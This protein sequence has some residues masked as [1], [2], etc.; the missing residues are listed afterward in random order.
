MAGTL[1]DRTITV[2]SIVSSYT[3]EELNQE[4]HSKAEYEN[5]I[6]A[7][8]AIYKIVNFSDTKDV[9]TL[10]KYA[11]EWIRQNYYDGVLSFT[12]K[13]VDLHLLGYD[14]DKFLCGD[15]IP[16]NFLD[17]VKTP[18]KKTLTCMSASYD[19]LKPEN[20]QFKIGVPDV[21]ANVKW[22]ESVANSTSSGKSNKKTTDTNVEDKIEEVLVDNGI[23]IS[24]TETPA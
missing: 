10:T 20:S 17:G 8:G 13:A 19:L 11:K 2:P 5:A 21:A 4:Y 12:A 6:S 15:R 23:V 22:R 24:R 9:A 14:K 1:A 18:T 7:Y 3:D 16:V